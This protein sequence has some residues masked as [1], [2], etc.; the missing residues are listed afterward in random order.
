MTRSRLTLSTQIATI[1]TRWRT[2]NLSSATRLFVLERFRTR[3]INTMFIDERQTVSRRST[4]N[5]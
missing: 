1:D 2:G 3:A 5:D 4:A